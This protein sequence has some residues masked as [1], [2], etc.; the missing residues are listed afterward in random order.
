MKLFPSGAAENEEE[1]MSNP[2]QSQLK[3]KPYLVDEAM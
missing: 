2:H 3:N 1:Q